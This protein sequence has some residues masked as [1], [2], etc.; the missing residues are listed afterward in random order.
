VVATLQSPRGGPD[1][2]SEE[3]TIDGHWS[4][5]AGQGGAGRAD[6]EGRRTSRSRLP[7]DRA[8]KSVAL[9]K[10]RAGRGFRIA[11]HGR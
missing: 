5:A 6:A 8:Q 4:R 10:H 9:R 2:Q 11:L 3:C 7:A 1:E